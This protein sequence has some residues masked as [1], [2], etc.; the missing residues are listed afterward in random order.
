M[1]SYPR[2]QYNLHQN[3]ITDLYTEGE[4]WQLDY[5]TIKTQ[6]PVGPCA[7]N[8]LQYADSVNHSPKAK[9]NLVGGLE[10]WTR[11]SMVVPSSA[12]SWIRIH[13]YSGS[14]LYFYKRADSVRL[15]FVDYKLKVLQSICCNCWQMNNSSHMTCMCVND[16][17][18]RV[19]HT[20][21][22]CGIFYSRHFTKR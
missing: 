6:S 3:D 11:V 9:I 14:L 20:P 5:P 19:R 2:W 13:V 12:M 22:S 10:C 8:T 17:N 16:T 4:M 15:T 18:A 21:R 7:V 1:P